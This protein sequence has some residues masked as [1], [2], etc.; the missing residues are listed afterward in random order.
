MRTY[1]YDGSFDG[2][3]TAYFYA[4]KDKDIYDI[5]RQT[6]YQPDLVSKPLDI[7]TEEDKA[8]RIVTSV[9]QTLSSQTMRNLYLLYLSEL[10]RC[11]FLGLQYLRLCYQQGAAVYLAKHHP[12]IRQV[13]DTCRKVKLELDHMKG[14]LRFQEI[15][16]LVFYA[17][18][19]PDHNQLPLLQPHLERRFSDQK[20]IVFDEKRQYALVYNLHHSIMIPFTQEDAQ[21]LLQNCHDNCIELFRRYFHT[22]TISQ[23]SNANLQAGYMPHRY[24]KYMPETQPEDN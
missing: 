22:I 12:I 13:D 8:Q 4:Y 16:P 10:P 9:Q 24:R 21:H 14:F 17:C 19:A 20:M 5:C 6:H 1:L 11:D 23:R 15:E 7:S 2:L 18:F 3:L